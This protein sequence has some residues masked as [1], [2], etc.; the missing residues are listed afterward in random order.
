MWPWVVAALAGNHVVLSLIGLWP[1]STLLGPNLQRLPPASIARNEIC[2]TLDDGPDPDVTPAVLEI[3][4][5]YRCKASFFPIGER[6]ASHPDAV[7][8]IVRHGHCVENHS[9]RHS[10]W[11]SF[12]G[13]GR[14]R[15]EIEAAQEVISRTAGLAPEFFRAPAGLRNPL[16]GPVISQLGLNFVSWTRRGFDTVTGDPALVFERL[17]RD[18]AAGDILLLHDGSSAR[19]PNGRPVVLEVLPM[20]LERVVAAGL[21]PVTLRA[22]MQ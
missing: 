12:Y 18:L 17:V 14:F 22:A 13:L 10:L 3:L 9:F 4:D 16:L 11:F 6:V 1:R 21:K 2:I 8:E 5:R 7:R 20:L 19:M 15:R